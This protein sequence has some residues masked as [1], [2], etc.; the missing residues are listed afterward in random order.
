MIYVALLSAA[1]LP[2]RACRF[3]RMNTKKLVMMY[4]MYF[5]FF[6]FSTSSG[7]DV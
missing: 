2:L 1:F 4:F 6:S 5:L 3:F 7:L